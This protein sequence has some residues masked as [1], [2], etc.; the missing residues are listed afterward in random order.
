MTA[1][2]MRVDLSTLVDALVSGNSDQIV[3]AAR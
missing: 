1:T 2:E 3:A